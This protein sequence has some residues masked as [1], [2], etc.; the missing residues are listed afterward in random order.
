MKIREYSVVKNA[1]R[2]TLLL[3]RQKK[4]KKKNTKKITTK[5]KDDTQKSSYNLAA[6]TIK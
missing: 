3:K 5:I 2:K 1:L 4:K 6:V